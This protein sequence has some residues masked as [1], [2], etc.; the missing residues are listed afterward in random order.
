[1][2]IS[3]SRRTDVA[4]FYTPWLM[5]RITAGYCAVPNPFNRNQIS[6]IDLRPEAVDAFV[7]WTRNPRPLFA[8]LDRLDAAGYRYYFQF[9]IINNPR[10]IDPKSPPLDSAL[11]TFIALSKRIGA[12]RVM[13][14]Y[15]PIVFSPITS[16]AYHLENFTQIANALE[17]HTKRT[18]ISIVDAYAKAKRRMAAL[19]AQGIPVADDVAATEWLMP[20][21]LAVAERHGMELQS[22]AET[23]DMTAY[24]IYPGKCVDDVL[25][26]RV[27]GHDVNHKKD[28]GQREACGCVQSKDIGMYDSCLFGCEYCYATSSFATAR[29]NHEQHDPLSPSLVGWYD[30]APPT[31]QPTRNKIEA[32]AAVPGQLSF[33]LE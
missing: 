26:Q 4:A 2:I 17:G 11:N 27:F 6:H 18:V 22:C 20:K 3:A 19:A 16:T 9:T 29:T 14:R 13:W 32:V 30:A 23:I 8:H 21:L 28:A 5:N 33:D 24:G 15:D 7:F 25:I 31:T 12:E 1:M 10:E